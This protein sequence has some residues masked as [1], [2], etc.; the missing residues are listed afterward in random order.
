[1]LTLALLAPALKL[2]ACVLVVR[3]GWWLLGDLV[4]DTF[5]LPL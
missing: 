4:L 3:I 1:M 5:D 2:A